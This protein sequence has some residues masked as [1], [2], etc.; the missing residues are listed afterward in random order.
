MA[1]IGKLDVSVRSPPALPP[2]T[3]AL[4]VSRVW[5]AP[6]FDPVGWKSQYEDRFSKYLGEGPLT[7]EAHAAARQSVVVTFEH[8]RDQLQKVHQRKADDRLESAIGGGVL[9]AM[10]AAI[11]L[12]SGA[13]NRRMYLGALKAVELVGRVIP[14][15]APSERQLGWGRAGAHSAWVFGEA[16]A[17][18]LA[19]NAVYQGG[20]LIGDW[21]DDQSAMKVAELAV[22]AAK[23]QLDCR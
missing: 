5:G 8:D 2:V 9:T 13:V 18:V 7:P 21:L 23:S 16:V 12:G 6:E 22:F 1:P 14:P 11:C 19:A 10:G 4:P 15:L 20:R 17:G 3:C